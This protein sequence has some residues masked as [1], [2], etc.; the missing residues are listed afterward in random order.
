MEGIS[1]LKRF[2]ESPKMIG[3]VWPSSKRLAK[4]M[5]S[6]IDF[7]GAKCIV[8]YGPGT[9]VFTKELIEK[10][11][12]DTILFLVELNEELYHGLQKKYENTPNVYVIH[13]SAEKVDEHLQ[14]YGYAEVDYIISGLP[15]AAFPEELSQRI[16]E[17]TLRVLK[18]E[19][20]FITFQYTL[21]KKK[22]INGFFDSIQLNYELINLPPA[23][24]F[25]CKKQGL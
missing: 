13:D 6:T 12:P 21:L 17:T 7:A 14:Q 4:K 15:F 8:E 10:K 25:Y 24:I 3:S 5:V 2:M 18:Q 19:G 9:G 20:Q 1:F 16:F 22:F 11:Q 23:F